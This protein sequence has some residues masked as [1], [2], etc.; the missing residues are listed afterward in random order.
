V[1]KVV[2]V[3]ES[4]IA[5]AILFLLERQKAVVEG[6]GAVTLAAAM[7]GKAELAGRKACAVVSGG[8]ID[9]TLVSR[10]IQKGL[11]KEGRIAVLETVISDRPGS[12][13]SFLQVLAKNKA[14]VI[15]LHHDRDRLDL[16]LNRTAVEVHVETRGPEHIA[17]LQKALAAAGYDV[18]LGGG[19]P[20]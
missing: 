3:A 4:E 7:H 15:D 11:L 20:G 16:A 2:T 8:N 18:R 9:M 17:E 13:A 10:I 19:S 12:L 14:S 1:D 5:A 6:A